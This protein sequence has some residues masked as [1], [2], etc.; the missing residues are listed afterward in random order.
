[1]Q[2]AGGFKLPSPRKYVAGP[3]SPAEGGG[4]RDLFHV[5]HKVPA[6]DSPYVRAKHV[7]VRLSLLFFFSSVS[8]GED[9]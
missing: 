9:F 4:R 3:A 8:D 5:I 7:Q 2:G 1:M 6:G